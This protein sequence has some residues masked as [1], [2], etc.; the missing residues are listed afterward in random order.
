MGNKARFASS[1]D[2]A[3]GPLVVGLDVGSTA[4]RGGLYDARGLPIKGRGAKV[5]HSFTTAADG[6]VTID[7][8]QVTGEIAHCLDSIS[9]KLG[10]HAVS[11]VAMDTFASSLVGV[12]KDGKAVTPCFTYADSRCTPQLASLLAKFDVD[13]L[14]ERTGTRLHTSYLA[15]RLLW[16]KQTDPDAFKAARHWMSLGEY[17]QLQLAGTTAVATSTAAW[18]GLL[19][20][21]T[22]DWVAALLDAAGVAADQFSPIN[23]PDEPIKG[24]SSGTK[25]PALAESEWYASVTD[26]I[27]SHVGSGAVDETSVALAAGTSGAMRVLLGRSPKKV[28][29]GLW[30]YRIDR[31][32]SLLGG[33]VNDVGRV[34]SWVDT[35]V[36]LPDKTSLEDV[37]RRSPDPSTPLMLP[38]LTG[39]RS[40]GWRGDAR[41]VVTG[42]SAANDGGALAR[43]A[44][45]GVVLAYARVHEQLLAASSKSTHIVASGRVVQ[46]LPDLVAMIADGLQVP[47]DTATMSRATLHGTVLLTLD[48]LAPDVARE[49]TPMAGARQPTIANAEHYQGRRG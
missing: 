27:A 48:H 49:P 2:H 16:L 38:F 18:T 17:V 12:G 14:H 45:K 24:A 1:L 28:P 42:L 22:G 33:A 21:H 19:D 43:A 44:L 9:D 34:V 39:E 7:A 20:R 47:V 46:D 23:D 30:C 41:A 37:A 36:K 5:P 6:T 32:R 35:A 25:W 3:I 40:T 26:G 4:S 11:A 10:K 29:S 15:P 13:E 31:K 8:D